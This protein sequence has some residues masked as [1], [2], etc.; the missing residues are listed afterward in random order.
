M[1]AIRLGAILLLAI[2]LRW[3][4]FVGLVGADDIAIADNALRLL[5]SGPWLPMNHYAARVGL[6]YPLAGI[7]A[8]MG[9]GE[10]QTVVMPFFYSLLSI[11][12][13]YL[14]GARLAGTP[15]GLWAALFLALFPLDVAGASQLMPDLP[16]GATMALTFYLA[17]RVGDAQR[18][19]LWAIFAG[20]AWGLSYLIKVEAPLLALPMLVLLIMNREHWRAMLL[21]FVVLGAVIALES[22]IYWSAGG[23]IVHRLYAVQHHGDGKVMAAY[24]AVQL[25]V[26]PKAW[27]ITVYE[28]GLHYYLMF[29]AMLW[30]MATRQSRLYVIVVWALVL[31]LWLQFGGNPFAADYSVKS[32][33][34][35]YCEM[36]AVPMA[37][38]IGAFVARLWSLRSNT[39]ALM[40]TAAALSA[41]LF[42]I[43]FN[44]LSHESEHATKRAIDY[45]RAHDLFPVYMD[46]KSYDLAT[47]YLHGDPR[48]VQVHPLQVQDVKTNETA[49]VGPDAA[50]AYLLLNRDFM[51]Y[52]WR[53]YEI[54]PVDAG[55]FKDRELVFQVDNPGNRLAYLQARFLGAVGRLLPVAFLREKIGGTA[56]ELLAPEDVLL[57]GKAPTRG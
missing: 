27:F 21:V 28:F 41:G 36:L 22:L 33:L 49:G 40:V 50:A 57:F 42:F 38:L 47:I 32:H 14:I 25:W 34:N 15:A 11:V 16:Q 51:L 19:I 46:R 43:N 26:F 54:E 5:E 29:G 23:G 30:V 48:L 45:V 7:Y 39:A 37:V 10:W 31:L 8:L 2:A 24:S 9:V 52:G 20:L 12:L 17:L 3:A 55:Q 1:I 13:A 4:A 6:I 18:P 44:T 56:D 35:R 53:R